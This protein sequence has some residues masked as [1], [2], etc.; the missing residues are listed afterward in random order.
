MLPE[1]INSEMIIVS[2]N[3]SLTF[4]PECLKSD[5]FLDALGKAF[6]SKENCSVLLQD[7]VYEL[8]SKEFKT[9]LEGGENR[10]SYLFET[11]FEIKREIFI[12]GNIDGNFSELVFYE[13]P[14]SLNINK[15][16]LKFDNIH[17]N[18]KKEFSSSKGTFR[19]FF[20]LNISENFIEGLE[21]SG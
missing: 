7:R 6:R 16:L 17:L 12:K 15:L 9:F 14:I 19:C 21:V 20:C 2:K 8:D 11:S 18:F 10:D 13:Q 4:C 3:A 1:M 5:S